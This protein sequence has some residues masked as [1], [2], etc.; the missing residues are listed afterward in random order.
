MV[1]VAI[2]P[3]TKEGFRVKAKVQRQLHAAKRRIERRLGKWKLGDCS[4]PVLT[5]G[6]ICYERDACRS[7][8]CSTF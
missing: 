5:G 6:N 1:E 7:Q 2:N 4:R 8:C 3:L